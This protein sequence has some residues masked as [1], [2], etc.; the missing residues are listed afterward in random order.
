MRITEL[1]SE[2]DIVRLKR[3]IDVWSVVTGVVAAAALAACIALVSA[4]GTANAQR[5]ELLTVAVS[6]AAGWICI[7]IMA[8]VVTAGRRELVHANMLRTDERRRVE[9]EVAVTKERLIIRRSI[10]V[11][12]VEVRTAGETS[13]FLVCDTRAKCLESAKAVAVYIA[14]GYV[15]AYEVEP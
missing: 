2:K 11:R 3:K 8:F 1:Y 9:G 15:A 5:M 6:T 10:A 13:R 4:T 7:Y 12:R 14:N